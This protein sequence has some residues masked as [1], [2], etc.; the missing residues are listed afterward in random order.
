MSEVVA[1][2]LINLTAYPVRD[3][4]PKLLADKSA[5]RNIIFATDAYGTLPTDEIT[6]EILSEIGAEIQ[7]R[8]CKK[9]T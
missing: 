4:L 5:E 6:V 8:T 9:L 1:A 7:P 2:D 3:V